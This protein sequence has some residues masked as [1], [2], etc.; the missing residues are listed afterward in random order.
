M[1]RLRRLAAGL[2]VSIGQLSSRTQLTGGKRAVHRRRAPLV[3]RLHR[4]AR[5][6]GRGTPGAV[7]FGQFD[8]PHEHLVPGTTPVT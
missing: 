8:R 2:E 1:T 4:T 3:D 6:H 7:K 5:I